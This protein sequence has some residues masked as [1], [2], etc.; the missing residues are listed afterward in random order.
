MWYSL[1]SV[2]IGLDR[3]DVTKCSELSPEFHVIDGSSAWGVDKGDC[4][5]ALVEFTILVVSMRRET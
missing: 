4:Y 3:L 1:G 5:N 2:V